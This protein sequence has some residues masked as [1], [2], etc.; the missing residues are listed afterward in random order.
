MSG[1]VSLP[2]YAAYLDER[3]WIPQS[4]WGENGY[5]GFWASPEKAKTAHTLS[6]TGIYNK[7]YGGDLVAQC[8]YSD[9]L[10]SILPKVPY[11]KSGHRVIESAGMSTGVGVALGGDLQ[12]ATPPT[13]SAEL[14]TAPALQTNT[15]DVNLETE[16]LTGK[17]DIVTP[18]EIVQWG[19]TEFR[20]GIDYALGLDSDTLASAG[21]FLE[22]IDRAIGATTLQVTNHGYTA[23]DEDFMGVDR[24]TNTWFASYYNDNTDVDRVFQL[25]YLE[26]VYANI[27]PYA[28][29]PGGFNLVNVTGFDTGWRIN[30]AAG[31]AIYHPKED[32][33]VSLNGLSTQTGTAYNIRIP[34]VHGYPL[35]L[36]RANLASDTI[37][38][39]YTYNQ[40]YMGIKMLIPPASIQ[41]ADPIVVGSFL[42]RYVNYMYGQLYS[43]KS[44]AHGTIWD[45][46]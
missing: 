19:V 40:D 1:L 28:D 20:N 6:T 14:S 2:Q 35:Y 3:G 17:D 27:E 41:S 46:K 30:Q 13:Y 5:E 44:K 32:Y 10:L 24:S 34:T 7:I 25:S 21:T 23:A 43:L 8:L 45:L 37:T 12:T 42:H 11:E 15:V 38:R 39:V 4:F 33:S 36:M 26:D 16:A 18:S 29:G 31:P 9:N 22:S